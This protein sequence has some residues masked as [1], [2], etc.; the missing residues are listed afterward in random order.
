M[1]VGE[2][3]VRLR[4]DD[5]IWRLGPVIGVGRFG[6]VAVATDERGRRAALKY[7]KSEYAPDE[8]AIRGLLQEVSLLR[9][10]RHAAIPELLDQGVGSDG[11]PFF[12]MELLEGET[13]EQQ[14]RGLARPDTLI[15][16]GLA[17]QALD[18]LNYVH[19][20]GYVHRDLNPNNLFI[21]QDGSLKLLDFGLCRAIEFSGDALESRTGSGHLGTPGYIAPEQARGELALDARADL[22]SLGATLFVLLSGEPVHFGSRQ[23]QMIAVGSQSP[24][25][26]RAAMP[27]VPEDIAEWV[28][29]ALAFEAKNR[30]SNAAEMRRKLQ[31][32][33]TRLKAHSGPNIESRRI[34]RGLMESPDTLE[35]PGTPASENMQSLYLQLVHSPDR[36][37]PRVVELQSGSLVAVGRDSH[38]NTW[39]PSNCP[40]ISFIIS[41]SGLH[42]NSFARHI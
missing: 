19:G 42:S 3:G 32:I 21:T 10:L 38:Q 11:L 26:L 39:R 27:K 41:R 30:W 2:V 29:R 31:V 9:E 20:L 23:E 25:P 18:A 36:S 33:L 24:R 13:L 1:A 35:G 16:L 34:P 28:D 14:R 8:T 4:G 22:W 6:A 15:V 17:A 5:A 12:A 37:A 7:L 40:V